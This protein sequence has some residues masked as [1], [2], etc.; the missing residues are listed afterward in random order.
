MSCALQT[1]RR[2]S[3]LGFRHRE[4]RGS[5]G[6]SSAVA[7]FIS[8]SVLVA[9]LVISL[10]NPV[11][12]HRK[13]GQPPSLNDKSDVIYQC[14]SNRYCGYYAWSNEPWNNRP[15]EPHVAPQNDSNGL[16]SLLIVEDYY[17]ANTDDVAYWTAMYVPHRIYN[18][19]YYMS[20]YST[21][22]RRVVSTHELGHAFGLAHSYARTTNDLDYCR[23]SVMYPH[24]NQMVRCGQEGYL[25]F[26]DRDDWVALW[27]TG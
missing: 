8:F 18:N 24:A 12:A 27:G 3:S 26:H 21:N 14:Y 11:S 23:A 15:G 1:R 6:S 20:G 10:A 7:F 9:V 2:W 13:E 22:A 17:N 4:A 25:R 19:N 5:S 16:A